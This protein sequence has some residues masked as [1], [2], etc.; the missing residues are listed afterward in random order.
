MRVRRERAVAFQPV[1]AALRRRLTYCSGV[2]F[3]VLTQ[4]RFVDYVLRGFEHGFRIGLGSSPHRRTARNFLTAAT[5]AS[6][7]RGYFCGELEVGRIVGPVAPQWVEHV[8]PYSVIPK[9]HQPGRWRLITN[10]SA[11]RG[12]SVNDGIDA[13]LCSLSYARIND[14]I[15]IALDLGTGCL[16]AKLDLHAAYRHLGARSPGGPPVSRRALAGSAFPRRGS[17][18]RSPVSAE[19]FFGGS[20]RCFM[21]HD[22]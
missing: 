1:F 17:P 4:T 16:L 12:S 2:R 3:S 19:D 22:S 11:P 9:P 14:A 15:A 8:S 5:H 6:V 7:V 21:D 13:S 20:G 18:V 10:L